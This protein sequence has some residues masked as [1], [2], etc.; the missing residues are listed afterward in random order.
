MRKTDVNLKT[1]DEKLLRNVLNYISTLRNHKEVRLMFQLALRS[2]MRR[3]NFINLTIGDVLDDNNEVK[4]II[5]LN[6]SKSKGDTY[7]KYYV[8]DVLKKEIKQFLDGWDVEDKTRYLFVSPK[9][10]KP[11]NKCYISQLFTKIYATFGV[12]N[13]T[14]ATRRSFITS[15]L[16]KNIPITT[17]QHLVNHK[18]YASTSAY[19][20]TDV[21]R[22]KN[23]VNLFDVK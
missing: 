12:H 11:Y 8:S 7:N 20:N 21:N 23:V 15:M 4:D 10:N 14:H 6:P 1:I 22:L 5:I 18:S 16:D 17:I 9:T 13:S 19:Y 3:C 2:G